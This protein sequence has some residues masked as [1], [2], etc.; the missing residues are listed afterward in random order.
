[1]LLEREGNS[2]KVDTVEVRFRGFK[3]NQGRKGDFLVK[4]KG[5]RVKGSEAVELF[6]D[7]YQIP[8]GRLDHP[9]IAYRGYGRPRWFV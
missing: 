2:P 7:L 9:L 3:G 8:E 1:M 4:M 6:Q 5:V